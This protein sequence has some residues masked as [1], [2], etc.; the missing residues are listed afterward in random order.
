MREFINGATAIVHGAL[1]AGCDFFAGYPITPATP[2]LLNMMH[3][4]PKTGGVAIQGEDEISSIGMCIGAGLA[5]CLPMTATSGPGLSLYS[6]TIGLAIMAEIPLVIVDVQR[7]GP[8]T[9]GAT[10]V[11]QGDVQMARWG[12]SGGYPIIVLAPSCIADCFSLTMRAFNLSVRFQC[13]VII[14]TDKEINL[15]TATVELPQPPYPA[16]PEPLVKPAS[17][18]GKGVVRHS[19][20][21]T[22]DEYGRIT[23]D[24]QKIQ[25]MN[26][27]LLNKIMNHQVEIETVQFDYQVGADTLFLSYGVTACTMEA[28]VPLCRE[29]GKCVSSIKVQSLWPIPVAALNKAGQDVKRIV[30]GELNPGL[31]T[32]EIQ[33][34]FPSKEIV[35]LTRIDGRMIKPD[36]FVSACV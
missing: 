18:F 2:I 31:Y 30:I 24:P 23:K 1:A 20:G 16:R 22:H 7:L 19:T 6:E 28:A 10:T 35:S 33:S 26:N 12:T 25:A 15:T 13:P 4:M 17:A 36:D 8:S 34:L 29:M 5:G 11:G 27:K 32:R 9:G 14:L 3:L 21:S